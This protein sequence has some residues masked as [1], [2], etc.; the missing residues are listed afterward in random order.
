MRKTNNNKLAMTTMTALMAAIIFLATWLIKMPMPALNGGYINLGDFTIYL[1][2]IMLGNPWAAVAAALGS[3]FADF[4]G[5]WTQY[6]AA[7]FVIKGLMGFV[8][9]YFA[10][11]G[12]IWLFGAGTLISAVIMAGGYFAYE[13]L[14][15]SAGNQLGWA[16]ASA[17]LPMNTLQGLTCAAFALAVYKPVFTVRERVLK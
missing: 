5:G 14:L 11:N 8:A 6:M 1:G 4:A 9:A 12:N 17:G 15:Y 3:A 10:K 13:L 2:A 7:T 16:A